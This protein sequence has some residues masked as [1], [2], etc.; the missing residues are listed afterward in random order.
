MAAKHTNYSRGKAAKTTSQPVVGEGPKRRIYTK[1]GT[2]PIR[3]RKGPGLSY[4]HTG[5]Y[6]TDQKKVV[7]VEV[8]D[9]WGLLEKYAETRDGWVCLEFLGNNSVT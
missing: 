6:L 2:T 5:A 3:I 4:A 1:H 7:I 9:G 8:Q